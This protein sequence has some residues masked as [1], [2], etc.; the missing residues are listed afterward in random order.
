[1]LV[2]M[3]SVAAVVDS[4]ALGVAKDDIELL[5]NRNAVYMQYKSA[6]SPPPVA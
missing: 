5:T 1:M 4:E 6:C 2:I 3:T